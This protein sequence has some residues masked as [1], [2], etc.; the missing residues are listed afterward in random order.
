MKEIK[1]IKKTGFVK[2]ILIK[3]CRLFGYELIDQSTLEFPVSNKNS[4]DFI[5]IPGNKSISLGLGETLVT[6]KVKALYIIV[7]TCTS[8]K[9][10][11][12]NKKRIFEEDKA[13]NTFR[14]IN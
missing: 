12:Q 3:I 1:S 6:R 5:S 11:Y 9:L 13:E 4:Q 7:K 14:K 8:V 2:K 10:V